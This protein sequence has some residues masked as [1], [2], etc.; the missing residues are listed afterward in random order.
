MENQKLR[1]QVDYKIKHQ[2][3]TPTRITHIL[4]ATQR[5]VHSFSFVSHSHSRLS[6]HL[7][8]NVFLLNCSICFNEYEYILLSGSKQ[9]CIY[10]CII[11]VCMSASGRAGG[12]AVVR[13]GTSFHV[14]F[15]IQHLAYTFLTQLYAVSDVLITIFREQ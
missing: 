5:S 12:R 11:R 1:P 14:F 6:A 7:N 8:K 9:I 2:I 15:A 13:P 4:F 10:L 3:Q